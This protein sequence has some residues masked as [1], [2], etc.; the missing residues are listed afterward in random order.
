MNRMPILAGGAVLA[1]VVLC[2]GAV[3]VANAVATS[4]PSSQVLSISGVTTADPS[5]TPSATPTPSAT[6]EP[7]DDNGGVTVVK[8]SDPTKI[9]GRG[10]DHLGRHGADDPA[11]HDATDD[12]GGDDQNR[13]E[14]EPGHHEFRPGDDSNRGPGGGQ[15]DGDHDGFGGFSGGGDDGSGHH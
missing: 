10:C 13:G 4:A 2:G 7:G 1:A 11:D 5:A 9:G 3:T 8:P 12:N 14:N 6:A 15:D